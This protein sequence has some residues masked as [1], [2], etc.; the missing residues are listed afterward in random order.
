M[1]LVSL[2]LYHY[3]NLSGQKIEFCPGTNLLFG[4]NGQGKTNLL[5]AIYLLGYG[6][7]FR[8]ATPKDCIQHGSGEARVDGTIEHR[9]L[10]RD[11][12]IQIPLEEEKRQLL[13]GK[14]VGL[15]EFIGNF[16]ALAFTQE[17][18][19]VVRGGPAERRAFIDRALVMASPGHMQRIASYSRALKQ[20]N[21]ILGS[22]SGKRIQAGCGSCSKLGK[23]SCRRRAAMCYGTGS[24]T[25][26]R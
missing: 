8:T 25:S 15:S 12:G 19:K 26:S 2:R 22:C 4:Q 5:E 16:H 9:S 18:L 20:R 11:L 13:F 23:K 17:H 7:S 21:R 3:R 10:I 24:N 14:T 6:R 1:R